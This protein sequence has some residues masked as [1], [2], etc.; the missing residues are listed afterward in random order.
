MNNTDKLLEKLKTYTLN[1]IEAY[2]LMLTKKSYLGR[3]YRKENI[4]YV[5]EEIKDSKENMYLLKA[6][7]ED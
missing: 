5:F 3:F 2:D 4:L 7:F 6:I 1:E